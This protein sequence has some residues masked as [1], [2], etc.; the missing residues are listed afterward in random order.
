MHA[1]STTNND[2]KKRGK[3]SINKYATYL[4]RSRR[5]LPFFH[6]ECRNC[7]CSP[8]PSSLGSSTR[9]GDP[10][11]P[12]DWEPCQYDPPSIDGEVT[13]TASELSMITI[14]TDDEEE[15][16]PNDAAS[17]LETQSD[18]DTPQVCVSDIANKIINA[19]YQVNKESTIHSA[20]VAD[21]L[22][23]TMNTWLCI[24][25]TKTEIRALFQNCIIPKNVDALNP[26]RIN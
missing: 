12:E 16:F 24:C 4:Q 5:Q 8:L 14:P 22:A 15:G 11:D 13:D 6:D 23:Y 1:S 26:V 7:S 25:P 3:K 2:G 18:N 10:Y 17:Q 20:P 21:A 9:D 19:D